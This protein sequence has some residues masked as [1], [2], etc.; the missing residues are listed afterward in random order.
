[1]ILARLTTCTFKSWRTHLRRLR[2]SE[3]CL[4]FLCLQMLGR[5]YAQ[6]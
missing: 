1:L 4:C 6:L 2:S 3:T 5:F